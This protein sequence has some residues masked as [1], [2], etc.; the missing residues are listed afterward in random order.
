MR[1]LT[2]LF[3]ICLQAR[4]RPWHDLETETPWNRT[5]NRS[6]ET[7]A[8][9]ESFIFARFTDLLPLEC[10]EV[11]AGAHLRAGPL[12]S[13]WMLYLYGES[14]SQHRTWT[15][16]D[17]RWARVWTGHDYRVSG[18]R[19]DPIGFRTQYTSYEQLTR[20]PLGIW[21]NASSFFGHLL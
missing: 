18:L 5:W 11:H 12:F 8:Y 19:Y 13:Q 3:F 1:W 7:S 4:Y 15:G 16:F 21:N 14:I 10:H 2:S 9:K 17:Q 6:S 20:G